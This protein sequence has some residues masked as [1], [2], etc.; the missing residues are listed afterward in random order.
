[1]HIIFNSECKLI[2]S[3]DYGLGCFTAA[4]MPYLYD[5]LIEFAI[6]V[7]DTSALENVIWDDSETLIHMFWL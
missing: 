5:F 2:G 4:A 7:F 6:W 1:M 3:W